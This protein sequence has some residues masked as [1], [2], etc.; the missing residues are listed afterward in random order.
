MDFFYVYKSLAH[1]EKD[2]YVQPLILDERLAHIAAARER[3]DTRI[4]WLAD[5]MKNDL[6]HAF[7]DR[8]NSEFVISPEGK[9][10]IARSWSD[11]EQLRFAQT[12]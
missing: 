5:S 12:S 11:P 7:G 8:N 9:L 3:L 1:P 2:G 10:V 4:P 6:K